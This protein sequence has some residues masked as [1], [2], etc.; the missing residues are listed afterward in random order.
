MANTISSRTFRDEMKS[1]VLQEILHSATVTEAIA[2]VDR[3][4]R[5][6]IQNPY[7]S[8][9]TVVIQALAGTYTP[10]AFT[11][12]DDAL[13][14]T[15]ELIVSEHIMDFEE[16]LSSFDLFMERTKTLAWKVKDKLDVQV[17][18]DVLGVAGIGTLAVTGGFQTFGV[19]KAL[20]ALN[21]LLAGYS[22]DLN[23]MFLVIE[24]TDIQ[25]FLL[26]QTSTGF[27]MADLAL[28][29]GLMG[30]YLGVDIFVVRAGQH[31]ASH[32]LAGIKRK[33]TVA[34]PVEWKHDEKAVSGK[35]G[36]EMV[37]YGYYGFK[38]WNNYKALIIDVNIT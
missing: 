25:A 7:P 15:Q 6:V 36:K 31:P 12:T 26:A 20:G 16:S 29:N 13:T 33:F 22:Q 21:G 4:G 2:D 30:N 10:A 27:Q 19:N 5:K 8:T 24:S 28:R 3:S 32:R 1:T 37:T 9:P 18:S 23:D 34:L 35:T 38:V 11:T 14:V 17:L